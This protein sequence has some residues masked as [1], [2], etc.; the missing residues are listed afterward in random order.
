VLI[1]V[2]WSCFAAEFELTLLP[3][4]YFQA[5]TELRPNSAEVTLLPGAYFSSLLELRT[6]S[7]VM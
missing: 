7:H 5:P 4:A 3:G 1:G 6:V 2:D